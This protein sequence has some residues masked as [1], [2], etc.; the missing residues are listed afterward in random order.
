[1]EDGNYCQSEQVGYPTV[2]LPSSQNAQRVGWEAGYVVNFLNPAVTVNR[3]IRA[4]STVYKRLV[5]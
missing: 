3:W 2:E 1:M 5:K 4:R